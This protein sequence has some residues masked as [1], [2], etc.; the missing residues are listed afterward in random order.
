MPSAENADPVEFL[1]S[2][3]WS[4]LD[5]LGDGDVV[6]ASGLTIVRWHG[7]GAITCYQAW[8]DE[9]H[10]GHS[11]ASGNMTPGELWLWTDGQAFVVASEL[12][13]LYAGA[14]KRLHDKTTL[15]VTSPVSPG[16]DVEVS[17]SAPPPATWTV[18]RK[19]VF[20][21]PNSDAVETM[22]VKD[23]G[24]S[25]VVVDATTPFPA[26][27]LVGRD[28]QPVGV[29]AVGG[30]F[31]M[32]NS[33]TPGAHEYQSHLPWDISSQDRGPIVIHTPVYLYSEDPREIRGHLRGVFV[34]ADAEA[35]KIYTLADGDYIALPAATGG[36]MLL[37]P[38]F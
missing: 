36:K 9:E 8:D 32:V 1:I 11:P 24:E 7:D 28:P 26:G 10:T 38:M 18:G 15:M 19:V 4:I 34:S 14:I 37:V 23:R 29:G 27:S 17:L 13:S 6:L 31:H 35:G 2:N 25:Y 30:P 5:D 22:V 3:G 16:S 12:D 33:L 20:L 21:D